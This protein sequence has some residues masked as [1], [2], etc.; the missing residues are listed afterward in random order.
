[1]IVFLDFD[2]VLHPNA[3]YKVRG[4]ALLKASDHA[5]FEH[6]SRLVQ[7]LAMYPEIR[8]VLSTSWV[9]HFGFEYTKECVCDALQLRIKGATWHSSMN[10]NHWETLTRY[11]QIEL[12]VQRHNLIEW[13]AIDD[14]VLGWPDTQ[15]HHLVQ[16]HGWHGLGDEG[17][18]ADL[19][20][21]LGG[22]KQ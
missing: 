22:T 12:Y 3:A 5:L 9:S 11:E 10:K 21:K 17:A 13:V 14:D 8:I 18:Y 1:M 19:M 16:T 7:A 2:G 20:M 4:G 6:E 15:R